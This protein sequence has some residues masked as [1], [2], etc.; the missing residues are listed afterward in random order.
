MK[1]CRL[2]REQD[3]PTPSSRLSTIESTPSI[4]ANRQMEPQKLGRF[5]QGRARLDRDEGPLQGAGPALRNGQR[6]RAGRR[7]LP[8]QRAGRGGAAECELPAAEVRA[9]GTAGG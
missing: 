9:S 2:I 4:A 8:D 6:V 3:A 1:C 5:V 7:T